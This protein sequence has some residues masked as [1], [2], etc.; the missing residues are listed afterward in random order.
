MAAKFPTSVATVNE[1][2]DAKNNT[3]VTLD[4]NINNSVTTINVND[5]SNIPTAGKLTFYDDNSYEV[6]TYTGKTAT[7]LTG[8]TRGDDS[9][10]AT[11]HTDGAKIGVV[12]SAEYHNILADEIIAIA[13]NLSDRIGLS[14][15]Q[16]LAPL[17]SEALPTYAFTGDPN[18]GVW[19]A[20]ADTICF[21][22][23]GSERTRIASDGV[24]IIGHT[25]NTKAG[26]VLE[27][28]KASASVTFTAAAWSSAAALHAGGI[29]FTRSRSDTIGT[30]TATL[31]EDQLAEFEIFGSHSGNGLSELAAAIRV[32]QDGAAG[33]S[34]VPAR[35]EFMTGTSTVTA[36]TRMTLD[37]DG[38]LGLGIVAGDSLLHVHKATA[39]SV[40]ALASTLLT[41]ENSG[42]AT[43]SFLV[44]NTS[45]STIAFGDVD[46]NARYQIN[47][48]H[49]GEEMQFICSTEIIAIADN[50]IGFFAVTPVVRASAYTPTNV[51]TDRSYDAD[52]T[53]VAE[54][55]DVVGTLIADLQAYG[56][57]Q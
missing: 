9:T 24:F 38:N 28:N 12:Q 35:F 57:L 13:Q 21:S 44:P 42:N 30:Y 2:L 10:T 1:L 18:T 45:A 5:T 17:G 36:A 8:V 6:V 31:A 23:A 51:V 7:S 49:S 33:A 52:A 40:T 37:S 16:L 19:S 54:L 53:T 34:R 50:K 14:A 47:V 27:I 20:A 56:L 43:L 3:E 26:S 29:F 22:T 48:D 41:L 4:G 55:A 39:G 46:N 25:T 15:T 32:F 11:S